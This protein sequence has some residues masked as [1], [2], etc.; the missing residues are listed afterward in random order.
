MESNKKNIQD[1][2]VDSLAK[3][4]TE[5]EKRQDK[6]EEIGLPN[7]PSKI[8]ELEKNVAETSKMNFQQYQENIDR[9]DKQLNQFDGKIAAIPKEIP[10]KNTVQFD[11]RSKFVIRIIVGLT[12]T[13]AILIDM[14]VSVLFENSRRADETNKFLILRGFYPD[15]AK[16]IDTSYANN[17]DFLIKKAEANI[18]EQKTMSEAAFAAEQAAEKSRLANE[19]LQKLNGKIKGG[20]HN[21]NNRQKVR[22]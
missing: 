8:A 14:T 13:V 9:F 2:I 5:L 21:K 1:E 20:K 15:V 3:K 12:L 18:D 6:V 10:I 7:L 11:T 22:N 17:K 19:K 4:L 16:D